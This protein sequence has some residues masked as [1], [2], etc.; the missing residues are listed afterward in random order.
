M[1]A[2]IS[3]W[4]DVFNQKYYKPAAYT[5]QVTKSIHN[6]LKGQQLS[7]VCTWDDSTQHKIS[8]AETSPRIH[9]VFSESNATQHS[10]I[11]TC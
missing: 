6:R 1:L 3:A 10:Q 7:T 11:K 5:I 8:N 2:L 9:L 4:I